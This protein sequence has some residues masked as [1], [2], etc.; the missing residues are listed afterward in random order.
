MMHQRK[1]GVLDA[2]MR[3]WKSLGLKGFYRGFIGYSMVHF[4]MGTIML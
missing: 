3:I 4:F 2:S 1:E